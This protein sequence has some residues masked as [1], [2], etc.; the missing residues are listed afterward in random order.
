M[1]LESVANVSTLPTLLDGG[2]EALAEQLA[3]SLGPSGQAVLVQQCSSRGAFKAA[4]RAVRRFGLEAQFPEARLQYSLS[5]VRKLGAK[6]AWEVGIAFCGT[7]PALQAALLAEAEAAGERGVAAELAAAFGLTLSADSAAG[8]AAAAGRAA[9]AAERYLALQYPEA[10][11]MVGTQSELADCADCLAAADCIGLDA[12]WCACG[13]GP[14]VDPTTRG[15][16]VRCL[17]PL[18]IPCATAKPGG[19]TS[20]G[21]RML[22]TGR[23]ARK[24]RQAAAAARGWRC[25]S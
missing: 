2:H 18:L 11:R 15:R 10:V 3:A 17:G 19:R 1:R 6:G 12:E 4:F 7:D 13:A 9:A 14:A 21:P 22:R 5:T 20:A 16:I 24:T 23:R 8:A 25:S